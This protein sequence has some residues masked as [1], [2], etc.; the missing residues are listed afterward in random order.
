[1]TIDRARRNCKK[2]VRQSNLYS[3]VYPDLDVSK[4]YLEHLVENIN[5]RLN[6]FVASF[7]FYTDDKNVFNYLEKKFPSSG[8]LGT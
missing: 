1:M 3:I 8:I 6:N 4:F 2:E 5:P 7:L